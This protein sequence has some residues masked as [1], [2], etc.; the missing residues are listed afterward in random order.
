MASLHYHKWLPN[1]HFISSEG[2]LVNE[3]RWIEGV[4]F[5]LNERWK[6]GKLVWTYQET[7]PPEFE[8]LA[9]KYTPSVLFLDQALRMRH[10]LYGVAGPNHRNQELELYAA[11]TWS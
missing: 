6:H 3:N 4:L 7:V 1:P 9:R 10:G 5:L 8:R 2:T 11:D